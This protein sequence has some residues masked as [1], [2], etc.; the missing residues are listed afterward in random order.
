[1]NVFEVHRRIIDDY[2]RYIRSFI[3]IDDE[4]IRSTVD[5]ELAKGK[6]WPEPLLQFGAVELD[7]D[8][9]RLVGE[10]MTFLSPR[11]GVP[12]DAVD[13]EYTFYGIATLAL[14]V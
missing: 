8:A 12:D 2:E 9:V 6:L 4:E 7:D 5:A 1:M 11:L 10:V 14:T 13:V 3:R